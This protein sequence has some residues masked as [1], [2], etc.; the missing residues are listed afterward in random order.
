MRSL[1]RQ[2]RVTGIHMRSSSSSTIQSV[3]IARFNTD[4]NATSKVKPSSLSRR[5][6][7]CASFIPRSLSG[8]S[9]QPVKR[10]SRFHW[11]WPWRKST[12]LVMEEEIV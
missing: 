8:T 4:V 7:A 6:A 11:L 12:S 9:T 3:L 1:M 2:L 5:P 10:L